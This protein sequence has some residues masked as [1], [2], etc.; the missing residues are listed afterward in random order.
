MAFRATVFAAFVVG[1]AEA[2]A[3][4]PVGASRVAVKSARQ[5][6]AMGTF[7]EDLQ[8]KRFFNR[9]TFKV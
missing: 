7:V 5:N 8:Y 3:P 1:A 9:F 4:S 2:F 6:L